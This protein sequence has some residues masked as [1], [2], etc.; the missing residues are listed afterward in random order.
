M[1]KNVVKER[2]KAGQPAFGSFINYYSPNVVEILGYCGLDFV[3][4]DA[5]HGSMSPRDCEDMVRAAD[6]AGLTTIIRIAE[7]TQQNILRYLDTGALGVQMPMI[8]SRADAELAVRSVKYYPEGRRGL[9]GTRAAK[10]GLVEPLGEYVQQA[11]AETLVV[12]HVETVQA[13]ET[14]PE[15]LEVPGIDVV[16]IG[17]TDLS[18]A[19]GYPGRPQEASV[20]AAIDR[21]IKQV[22]DAGKVVGTIVRDGEQAKRL[23]DRGVLYLATTT[24]NLL[25]ASARQYMR[26]AR[27]S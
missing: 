27:G 19:M 5:E 26:E 18:Q 8:N 24:I 22:L 9:A 6:T 25:A 23:V 3:I 20:Q 1:R 13:L 16:F 14:L 11:N 10:Y 21:T 4:V 12:T 15:V 7:N 2:L 17:P